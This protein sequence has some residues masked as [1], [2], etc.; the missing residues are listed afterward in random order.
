[1]K[2]KL[3]WGLLALFIV[4][5]AAVVL[6]WRYGRGERWPAEIAHANG[7]LEMARVDLAVKYGGR[8]IELPVHEGDVLAAGAI[9]ARQDDAELRAQLEAATAARARAADAAQRA[10]A[11]TNARIARQRLARLEW[12]ET[13]KLFNEG[14]VSAVERDRRRIALDG[15]QAGVDAARAALGEARATVAE[16]D[17][18]VTRLKAV[19]AETTVLAP[20]AGRVEYRVVEIGTVLPPGGRVVSLLNPDDIYFTVFLPAPQ[21]GRLAIGAPARIVLDAFPGEVIPARIGYVASEAQ[22]TPKYVETEGERAK[23][24]YRIK[25]QLPVEVARKL[26]ARLKAGMTGDGYVRL[27]PAKPWPATLALRGE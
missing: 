5:L 11:E 10:Q 9:V 6:W 8:V 19:L 14:Q 25:L 26:A 24:M 3:R 27:D 4:L 16:S 18:Q 12:S 1:M 20:L 22:F 2:N 17:A 13:T 15:E 7:R 21:A 23:L